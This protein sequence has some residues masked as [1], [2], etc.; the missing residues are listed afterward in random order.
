M[1]LQKDPSIILMKMIEDASKR[2]RAIEDDCDRFSV[3]P[4][5][6]CVYTAWVGYRSALQD[7]LLELRGFGSAGRSD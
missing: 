4:N 7:A 5:D 3:A 6:N 1:S 2:I